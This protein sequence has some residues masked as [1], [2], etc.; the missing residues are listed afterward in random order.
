MGGGGGGGRKPTV[1]CVPRCRCRWACVC[2]WGYAD[3]RSCG[4]AAVGG[5]GR[6]GKKT[7]GR[8]RAVEGVEGDDRATIGTQ[9][10][11]L[12][13]GLSLWSG[14]ACALW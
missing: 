11:L 14:G 9:L 8:A 10:Q 12:R 13:C 6:E 4:G 1:A 7:A 3:K 5:G 2:R